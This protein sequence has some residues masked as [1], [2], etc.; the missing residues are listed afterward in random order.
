MVK[1]Q[2]RV[3]M[4]QKLFLREMLFSRLHSPHTLVVRDAS[5]VLISGSSIMTKYSVTRHAA[6]DRPTSRRPSLFQS[7]LSAR[8]QYPAA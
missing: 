7:Q 4:A 6:R 5:V 3:N 1:I 8:T 2:V